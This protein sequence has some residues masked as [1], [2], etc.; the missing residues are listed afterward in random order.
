MCPGWTGR[1]EGELSHRSPEF[2]AINTKTEQGLRRLLS[3]PEDYAVLF[4][5]GGGS[6][7]FRWSR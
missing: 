6:G 5:Q 3:I 2:E 4:L 1:N 7:Q